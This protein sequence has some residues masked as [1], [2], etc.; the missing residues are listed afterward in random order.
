MSVSMDKTM[1]I[2]FA[3]LGAKSLYFNYTLGGLD[4]YRDEIAILNR[5]GYAHTSHDVLDRSGQ[6]LTIAVL[7]KDGEVRK[8]YEL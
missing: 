4:Q 6:P 5:N 3:Q 2:D 8:V 1:E 7:H